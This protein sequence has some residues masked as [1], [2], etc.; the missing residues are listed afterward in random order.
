M[1]KIDS[2][3]IIIQPSEKFVNEGYIVFKLND[4]KFCH[5]LDYNLPEL[6]DDLIYSF[7]KKRN[8]YSDALYNLS[9]NDLVNLEN[10]N[11]ELKRKL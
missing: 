1:A 7:S 5:A 6:I 2:F 11:K 4:I 9:K 8:N 3:S 10:C